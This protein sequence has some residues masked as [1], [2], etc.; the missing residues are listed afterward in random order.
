[1]FKILFICTANICRTPIAKYYLRDKVKKTGLSGKIEVDSAGTWARGGQSAAEN[2]IAV[3][4]ENKLDASEHTSTGITAA[5]MNDSDLILCMSIQHKLDLVSIFPQ[6]ADKIFLLKEYS[7]ETP[8]K[9]L[10]IPDPYGRKIEVYR[11]VFREIASEID[12]FFP[13]IKRLV[14]NGAVAFSDQGKRA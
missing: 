7:N 10:S 1:M 2:S 9:R 11:E 6:H 8:E 3:C 12:R 5:I 4:K 13:E 14:S